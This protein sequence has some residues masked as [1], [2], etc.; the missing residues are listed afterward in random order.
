MEDALD[1]QFVRTL[2]CPASGQTLSFFPGQSPFLATLPA[3]ETADWTGVLVCA[4]GLSFYPV[5]GG[6]P[7]L[8]PEELRSV[9]DGASG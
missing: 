9:R 5:R 7:V 6:V 2:R 4:D 8:L 3:R 1:M